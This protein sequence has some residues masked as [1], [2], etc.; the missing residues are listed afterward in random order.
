MYIEYQYCLAYFPFKLFQV[1]FFLECKEYARFA[2]TKEE[3]PVLSLFPTF[4][5]NLECAFE[6]EELIVGGKKAKK[7]EFPHMVSF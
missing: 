1:N 7:Q 4:S 3:S 6:K 5:N 2:F